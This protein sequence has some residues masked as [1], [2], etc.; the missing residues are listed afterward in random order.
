MKVLRPALKKSEGKMLSVFKARLRA[1]G[2]VERRLA[3]AERAERRA[4]QQAA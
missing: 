3:A 2:S 4:A 1:V